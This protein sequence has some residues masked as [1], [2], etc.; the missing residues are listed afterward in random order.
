MTLDLRSERYT[1]ISKGRASV[2][3]FKGVGAVRECEQ[4]MQT[5]SGG[6]RHG[7]FEK[8]KGGQKARTSG[9]QMM[10]EKQAWGRQWRIL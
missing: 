2:S 9:W 6:K 3:T 7:L 4:H 5:S 8:L 10:L 1:S